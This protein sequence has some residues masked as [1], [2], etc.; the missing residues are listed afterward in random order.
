[1][2]WSHSER[3]ELLKQ[4]ERKPE[5]ELPRLQ[6]EEPREPAQTERRERELVEV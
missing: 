2:C 6:D 5:E 4:E 3:E 1:M